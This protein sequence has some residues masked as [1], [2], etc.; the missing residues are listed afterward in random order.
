[1][2][3]DDWYRNEHW[4]ADVETAFRAKL[5]RA[6]GQKPQYIKIQAAYLAKRYPGVALQL[7]DEYL[8]TGDQYFL[9]DAHGTRAKAFIALGR[10]DDAIAAYKEALAA[11]DAHP[12]YITTA[13]LDYPKLVAE[14]RLTNE[15]DSALDV[16]TTRF[17]P[18]DHEWPNNRYVWNGSAALIAY[19]MGDLAEAQEFAERA[20]RAAAQTESPFRYHRS[21]GLVRNASDEFGRRIKRIARPSKLR[22]LLRLISPN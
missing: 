14:C 3:R 6:R 16:L 19:E 7:I 17:E 15:Y 9:A 22:S 21:L 8:A 1:M 10:I 4:N 2:G 11:E 12:G 20:L 13:R 18:H 5:V